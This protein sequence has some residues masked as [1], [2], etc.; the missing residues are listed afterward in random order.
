MKAEFFLNNIIIQQLISG[1]NLVLT[2]DVTYFSG[3]LIQRF[4]T[5]EIWTPFILALFY[6]DII[7]ILLSKVYLCGSLCYLINTL[8]YSKSKYDQCY[9]R[10]V[11]PTLAKNIAEFQQSY[12]L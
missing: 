5:S 11:T 2:C 10:Y 7:W 1:T 9:K 6:Q 4:S 8:K 3:H 12:L